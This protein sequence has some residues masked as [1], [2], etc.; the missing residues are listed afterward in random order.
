MNH[1]TFEADFAQVVKSLPD[2]E[3]IVSRVHAKSCKI[4]DF[5]KLMTVCRLDIS[6]ALYDVD[7]TFLR[8]SPDSVAD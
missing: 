5:L 3:R 6:D 4:K 7:S 8:L 2:L 1:P